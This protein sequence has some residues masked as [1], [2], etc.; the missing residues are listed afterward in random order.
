VE[1]DEMDGACSNNGGEEECIYI[2]G[3]KAIG[4]ETT[5]TTK[6]WVDNI[7]MDLGEVPWGGV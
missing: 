2:T 1:G 6:T 7:R 3:K 5:R 4:K